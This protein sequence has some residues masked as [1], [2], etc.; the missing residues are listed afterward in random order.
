VAAACSS[1]PDTSG[2]PP[3][4]DDG[5]GSRSSST[6]ASSG[7]GSSSGTNSGSS[8][9]GGATTGT[10]ADASSGGIVDA[11]AAQACDAAIHFEAGSAAATAC[12]KC[13]Q[14]NCTMQLTMCQSDCVCVASVECLA[15]N[16]FNY[17]TSCMDAE[18]AIAAGDMGLTAVQACMTDKCALCTGTD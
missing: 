18:S 17:S 8:T 11:P 12:S 2:V 16:N 7:S 3:A 9:S 6:G 15:A 4:T 10:A 1:A 5:G 13:L 14:M